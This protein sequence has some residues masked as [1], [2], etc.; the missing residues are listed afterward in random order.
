MAR[1]LEHR[2]RLHPIRLVFFANNEPPGYY[3][4]EN[5]GSYQYLLRCEKENIKISAMVSIDEIGYFPEVPETQHYP[6]P[7]NTFYTHWGNFLSVVG[8]PASEDLTRELVGN[9]RSLVKFP[10]EGVVAQDPFSNGMENSDHYW[11]WKKNIPA[12]WINDTVFYR[13]PAYHSPKDTWEQVDVDKECRVV[14]GLTHVLE[15]L[16]DK[17]N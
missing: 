16:A 7:L 3:K 8:N 10:C 9:F 11:F 4:T 15:D 5:M 13:Y 17:N 1:L 6:S 2:Q 12:V 14:I